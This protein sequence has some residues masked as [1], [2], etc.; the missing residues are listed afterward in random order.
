MHV[1]ANPARF[2]KIARPLTAWLGWLGGAMIAGALAW[3]LFVA[4]AERLQG[5][6]VRILYVHV[7]AAWLAMAGWAAIAVASLIQLVWR[8]P[9]A[10]VAARAV[11][12]PGALFT[13][14]C[15]ATG[16]LWGKPTWGTWWEWDGRM[17]SMLVLLF[18][19]RA[20]QCRAGEGR[21]GAAHRH[22]RPG[23]CGEPADHPLFG[24]LVE[25]A[26]SGAEHLLHPRHLDDPCLDALAAA[27]LGARLHL[28]VRRDRADA[29]ARRARPQQGRGAAQADGRL[30]RIDPWPFIV[31]AYALTIMA[32]LAVT[33]WS[34]RAMRKAE[35]EAEALTGRQEN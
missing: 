33:L 16:S 20:R 3:G 4:P 9:L 10:L 5:E 21:G 14:I 7:P 12:V 15:L 34:W 26:S 8:H 19:Y 30:M 22:L 18:L 35:H 2:L 31:A 1:F 13:A 6:S 25:H 24:H 17:T 32:T 27:G 23:R 11:S 29:D 28:P